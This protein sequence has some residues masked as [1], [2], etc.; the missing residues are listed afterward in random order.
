MDTDEIRI[1]N[2]D[3]CPGDFQSLADFGSL[4]SRFDSGPLADGS[5]RADFCKASLT[6]AFQLRR[7][8]L[9]Q[10]PASHRLVSPVVPPSDSA[11]F[12]RV[13]QNSYRLRGWIGAIDIRR[14]L[15]AAGG[16]NQTAR[17]D[18]RSLLDFGSLPGNL[19][20]EQE[21]DG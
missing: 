19:R 8:H 7:R 15:G 5:S 11:T 17:A 1:M 3:L 9:A 16:R 21:V 6:V 4:L 14:L 12:R 13:L 10:V 2:I 18:F 20:K